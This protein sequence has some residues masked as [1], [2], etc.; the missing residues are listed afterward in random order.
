MTDALLNKAPMPVPPEREP[1]AGQ[2]VYLWLSREALL[3]EVGFRC[4]HLGC[5]RLEV[6]PVE[7]GAQRALLVRVDAPPHYVVE[8][9]RSQPPD[10]VLVFVAM[11][12]AAGLFIE[13][14]FEHPQAALWRKQWDVEREGWLFFSPTH[15]QHDQRRVEPP[16]AWRSIYEALDLAIEVD[17]EQTWQLAGE[18]VE[19]FQVAVRMQP[20]LRPAEP[21]VVLAGP[22]DEAALEEALAH[23]PPEVLE[24]VEVSVQRDADGETFFVLR[25]R[26]ARG[27]AVLARFAG[28][29]LT[30]F[31]GLERLLIPVDQ[32][33]RP[34]LRRDRYRELFELSRGELTIVSPSADRRVRLLRVA[35]ASFRPLERLVE[36]F[37]GFEP[38]QIEAISKDS[39]FDLGPYRVLPSRPDLLP[40]ERRGY[41]GEQREDLE[42]DSR[43][44]E[45]APD[46]SEPAEPVERPTP[47]EPPDEPDEQPVGELERRAR[48][49]ERE[50][51]VE[52]PSHSR[53]D[54]LRRAQIGLGRAENAAHCALEALWHAALG[55][56]IDSPDAGS[57]P[58]E[59][60]RQWLIDA[61]EA[62]GPRK[63]LEHW[64]DAIGVLEPP[65]DDAAGQWLIE[66]DRAL[67]HSDALPLKLEW[68][69]WRQVLRHNRDRRT[70]E[71]RRDD[72]LERLNASGLSAQDTAPCIRDRIIHG[73]PLGGDEADEEAADGQLE[74]TRSNL[75]TVAGFFTSGGSDLILA[76]AC[77]SAARV[78]GRMG[79]ES[80]VDDYLSRSGDL[81]GDYAA[82]GTFWRRLVD[83]FASD[84]GDRYE[85]A[86][87]RLLGAWAQVMGGTA[88][89]HC[90]RSEARAVLEAF[91]DSLEHLSARR[92]D[93]LIELRE[94][95]EARGRS[96]A[97]FVVESGRR[98][99]PL[100]ALPDEVEEMVEAAERAFARSAPDALFSAARAAL[101]HVTELLDDPGVD[102]MVVAAV[103]RRISK[104]LRQH[105]WDSARDPMTLI[106]PFVDSLPQ[107]TPEESK[108]P[109]YDAAARFSAARA[110]LDLG[111][112]ARA[113]ALANDTL[114]WLAETRIDCLDFVD[115]IR[116]E[117]LMVVELAPPEQRNLTLRHLTRT[118][119]AAHEGLPHRLNSPVYAFAWLEMLDQIAEA[120]VSKTR[121]ARRRLREWQEREEFMIRQ[122]LR[123]DRP[124]EESS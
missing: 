112:D 93:G 55:E 51:I 45:D 114:D 16:E 36:H 54:R 6:A 20:R 14:G 98:L 67:R 35:E 82:G 44:D 58:S 96:E 47:A 77:T 84:T 107:L 89:A 80:L 26:K 63:N 62:M 52:G 85:Q 117:A 115:V 56:I 33:L 86:L 49:L 76:A 27:T 116:S 3:A 2:S 122:V 19:P 104:V 38:A 31:R 22:D 83:F 102:M 65:G 103:I 69:A 75:T 92:R 11:V 99:F 101:A 40:R 48:E 4:L 68:L 91:E 1:P 37:A 30:R 24:Q 9:C 61:V 60:P 12:G 97:S 50:L 111:H 73:P 13:W 18:Q 59:Q 28:R 79:W 21:E 46:A 94:L 57:A 34:S 110:L 120:A 105:R 70:Y 23:A 17:S 42:E 108:M 71:A 32:T 64:Q 5:D 113:L 123:L 118:V 87:R 72:L 10:D 90:D 124:H 15:P 100:Y 78:A 81:L 25:E 74:R 95:I 121:Y 39:V 106:E 7:Y 109:L 41:E 8:W 29:R 66:A 119:Q 53:W 43:P 88:L